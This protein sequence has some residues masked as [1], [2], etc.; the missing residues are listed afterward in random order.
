M[1]IN[2]GVDVQGFTPV[3]LSRVL[4]MADGDYENV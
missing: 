4:E 2:V 1:A 3:S